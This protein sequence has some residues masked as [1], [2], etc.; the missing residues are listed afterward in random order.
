MS[1]FMQTSRLMAS[2]RSPQ[3]LSHNGEQNNAF[4]L[5]IYKKNLE[6]KETLTLSL[7]EELTLLN[8]LAQFELG[9]FLLENK[10]LNGF[11]TAYIILHGPQKKNLSELEQWTL[12]SAPVVKATQERFA[13]FQTELQQALKENTQMASIPCGLMDDLL[14]L[15][16]THHQNVKLVGIDLD[17]ESLN[18]AKQN[19]GLHQHK[20]VAF[21]QKN[22]W[23]LE[24]S[25]QF[26]LITSNGL[27][28]YEP[29]DKKI[30]DLY[31]EFHKS[32][33]P[34]GILITSFLTPPPA[35]S[36]DSSWRDYNQEDTLKQR[37]IFADI[38]GAQ[39][40]AFRTEAQTR[41]Q[42][43]EAGFKITKVI[44]DS[45]GMFPTVVA[46]KE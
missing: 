19:A 21:V 29:D 36:A 14:G 22:A 18:L 44:Y 16:Y 30:V 43:T 46:E 28:I 26:D 27:N 38:I 1:L 5:T 7:A 9:R 13:I 32:L 23:D 33:K 6:A 45:Q 2:E 34:K 8:E 20:N 40:Q 4:D 31:K 37:A 15:D 39:W 35:L 12:H 17:P 41:E 42:L 25:E 10:G 11:W 24:S 3:L